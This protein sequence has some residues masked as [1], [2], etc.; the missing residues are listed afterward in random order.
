MHATRFGRVTRG[1]SAYLTRRTTLGF[2][3]GG[4]LPVLGTALAAHAN[5]KKKKKAITLC[6]DGQTVKKPKKKARKLQKQGAT[7]G[8]CEPLRCGNGGPCTVFI[9]STPLQGS[10]IGGLD[11]ADAKC[12]ATAVGAGLPGTFKAWLSTAS[13]SPQTRFSN[14]PK[15]GPYHLV[16]NASDGS[17]PPPLVAETFALLTACPGGVCLQHAI[18]RDENGAV[19][20]GDTSVWTGTRQDGSSA[21]LNCLDWSSPSDLEFG[22]VGLA[23]Q[24]DA[25]WTESNLSSSCIAFP[26]NLYC[27][28]QAT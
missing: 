14:I 6:L 24:T 2:L 25:Q 20:P 23:V 1:L 26:R 18:D 4:S 16:P 22:L 12:Q 13:Q 8:K 19:M 21:N 9:R 5:K 11:G 28:E 27:F 3:V 17:N 10:D 7:K 15:A